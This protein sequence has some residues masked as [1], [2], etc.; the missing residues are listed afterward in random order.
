ME[1]KII[2]TSIITNTSDLDVTNKKTNKLIKYKKNLIALSENNIKYIDKFNKFLEL[3]NKTELLIEK[4]LDDKLKEINE[5]YDLL[6]YNIEIF[7]NI[8]NNFGYSM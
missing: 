8:K 4:K 2:S 6:D 3:L 5:I 1:N 7:R